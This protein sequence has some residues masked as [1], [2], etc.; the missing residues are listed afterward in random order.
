MMNQAQYSAR[1]IGHFG[2]AFSHYTHFTSP[3]RRYADLIVHRLIKH[4]VVDGRRYP[5]W[6]ED[7]LAQAG[8]MLSACEQ[9]SVKAERQLTSIKKARFIA[10][11]VGEVFEGMI[12]SVTKFGFFVLL[13]R[14]DVDGLIRMEELPSDYYIF[15]EQTLRL[16]GKRSGRV[17]A[18]SDPVQVQ[19]VSADTETGQVNFSLVDSGGDSASKSAKGYQ[20]RRSRRPS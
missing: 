17:Y 10:H 20:R 2:L 18:L 15:E 9:R 11:H 16:I 3:I 5:S 8:T 1:N 19:V 12:S 7:K 13:R 4:L 14:Y 6:S